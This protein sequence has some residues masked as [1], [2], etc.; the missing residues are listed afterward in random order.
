M[1]QTGATRISWWDFDGGGYNALMSDD[2]RPAE[3][4]ALCQVY[5][6]AKVVALLTGATPYT[7]P[8]TV[9]MPGLVH[10]LLKLASGR[11]LLIAW[12]PSTVKVTSTFKASQPVVFSG[13][14]TDG[15]VHWSNP[16]ATTLP[17]Y[18]ALPLN[19]AIIYVDP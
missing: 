8:I 9:T 6:A 16:K 5:C 1:P 18:G 14:H 15:L 19:Q 2:L 13:V 12:A 11:I 4:V 17:N 10:V 3:F 7:G